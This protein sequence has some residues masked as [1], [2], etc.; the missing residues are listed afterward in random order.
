MVGGA[1]V[2]DSN[3][4]EAVALAE[5]VHTRMHEAN[6]RCT[7]S[8]DEVTN[9][10]IQVVSGLLHR[11]T[12]TMKADE[13]MCGVMICSAQVWSQPWVSETPKINSY[14]CE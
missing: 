3:S 8:V 13:P 4:A 2:S 12:Y 14:K 11:I 10:S 7:F 6:P 1:S 5:S 9:H